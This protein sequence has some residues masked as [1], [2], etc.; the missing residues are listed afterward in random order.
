MQEATANR[1]LNENL[2]AVTAMSGKVFDDVEVRQFAESLLS[3]FNLPDKPQVLWAVV[4]SLKHLAGT[5]MTPRILFESARRIL[6]NEAFVTSGV[7]VPHWRGESIRV[8]VGVISSAQVRKPGRG[9]LLLEMYYRCLNGITAGMVYPYSISSGYMMKVFRSK[10][11]MKDLLYAMYPTSV[12]G[13]LMTVQM[14]V[15]NDYIR[16]TDITVSEKD[17]QYNKEL[18]DGRIHRKGCNGQKPSCYR[19]GATREQCRYAAT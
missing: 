15:V 11:G 9:S 7:P 8:H 6:M 12:T 17:K 19:C 18:I 16:W 4:Q 1:R 13:M 10:M 2:A 5:T 14:E 3:T